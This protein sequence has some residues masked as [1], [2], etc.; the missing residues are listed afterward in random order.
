[1]TDQLTRLIEEVLPPLGKERCHVWR[2]SRTPG[3][4]ETKYY[5]EV[6]RPMVHPRTQ[7]LLQWQ[8][9]VDFYHAM[10]RVWKIGTVLFGEDTKVRLRAWA[11]RMGRLMKKR[12]G[13][14]S[15]PPL[16]PPRRP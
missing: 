11:R 2:M 6:L 7:E 8:R 3:E 13:L 10:T 15:S 1:M 12:N 9:I 14:R 16:P 5:D 4:N